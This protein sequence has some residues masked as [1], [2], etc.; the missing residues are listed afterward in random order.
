LYFN[1]QKYRVALGKATQHSGFP[2]GKLTAGPAFV[3]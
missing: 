3:T 2:E 1:G